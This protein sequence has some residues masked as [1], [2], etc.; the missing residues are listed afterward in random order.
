MVRDTPEMRELS[1]SEQRDEAVLAV[2]R[3]GETVTDVAAWFE[4]ARKTVHEWLKKY[5][6]RSGR[7]GRSGGSVAPAAVVSASN[8]CGR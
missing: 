8:R 7:S 4:A 5:D 6:R 3:D 2:I 1:V